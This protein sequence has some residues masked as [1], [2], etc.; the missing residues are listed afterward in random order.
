MQDV[1]LLLGCEKRDLIGAM[2]I[3]T[4]VTLQQ[5]LT[6]WRVR[7]ARDLLRA[8]GIEIG[9]GSDAAGREGAME[10]LG[11]AEVPQE[12]LQRVAQRCG[13]RSYG[14]EGDSGA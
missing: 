8:E 11:L 2:R 12:E 14:H 9:N 6:G 13:W 7:Q 10:A 3:M 4:G 1:A 5:L